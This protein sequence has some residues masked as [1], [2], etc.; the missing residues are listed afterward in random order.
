VNGA[1]TLYSRTG[2]PLVKSRIVAF[3]SSRRRGGAVTPFTAVGATGIGAD[4]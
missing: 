3:H 2:K 4:M 1:G